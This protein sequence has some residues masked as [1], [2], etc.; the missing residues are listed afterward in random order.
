MTALGP[1]G[2]R[3]LI[4]VDDHVIEP[5][6]VWESRLPARLAERGPRVVPDDT[7]ATGES[8]VYDGKKLPP[9]PGICTAIGRDPEDVIRPLPYSEMRPG[10]YDSV[11]RVEDMDTDGVLASLCFPSVPR[12]CGQIFL[13]ADDK[14]LSLLC[15]RAYNDWMLDEWSGRAPGRFIP[16]MILPLWDVNLCVDELERTVAQ[17]AKS[18]CFSENVS[19]LGLPSIH[20]HD[21]Y[22]DPLWAVASEAGVP[23]AMHIG[24]SSKIPITAPDAPIIIAGVLT[25]MNAMKTCVDWLFSG[26]FSRFPA[27]K[28][29]LSE[30][31]IGWIPYVLERAEYT[32]DRQGAWAKKGDMAIL[33]VGGGGRPLTFDVGVVE[34]FRRNIFGCFIDDIVGAGS[35]DTIGIDNVMI[36]TD[37]PHTDSNFPHSIATAMSRLEGRTEEE[38]EKIFVGNA[39]RVFN[40]EPAEIPVAGPS[41]TASAR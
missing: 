2:R 28:V 34:M 14:E 8:W 40:F 23:V 12:F 15:V 5:P 16:N 41:L 7:S 13:E 9:I 31:G 32:L 27:L 19:D 21:D 3:W 17:G 20:N 39:C 37:Y 33:G 38:I 11:A 1:D 18:F 24:S 35:L 6:S 25:P 22:W 26:V 29:C 36:E 10:Y 4:S 30:G